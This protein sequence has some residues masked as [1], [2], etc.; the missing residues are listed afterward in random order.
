MECHICG[1]GQTCIYLACK[2]SRQPV[3]Y[4]VT[5]LR[6]LLVLRNLMITDQLLFGQTEVREQE[7]WAGYARVGY[8]GS[9]L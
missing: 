4:L 9:T 3:S 6:L 5:Y 2:I 7:K 8:I 1:E